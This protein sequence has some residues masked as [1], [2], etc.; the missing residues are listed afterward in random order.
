MTTLSEPHPL[1]GILAEGQ[2]RRL[3]D[4]LAYAF[5]VDDGAALVWVLGTGKSGTTA[6]PS[7]IGCVT[8]WQRWTRLCRA[9]CCR[10]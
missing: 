10:R 1:A 8:K 3:A 9:C 2:L 5:N 7:R 4:A 6:K